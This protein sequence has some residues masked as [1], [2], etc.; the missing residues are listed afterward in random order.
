MA[1]ND[2]SDVSIPD[3]KKMLSEYNKELVNLK[4]QKHIGQLTA[5]HRI[6]IARR[7]IARVKTVL[8]LANTEQ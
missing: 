5:P 6:R 4:V 1:N 3:L 7:N 2:K 8:H